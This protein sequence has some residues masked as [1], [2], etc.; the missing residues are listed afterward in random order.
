MTAGEW[1]GN[2]DNEANEEDPAKCWAIEERNERREETLRLKRIKLAKHSWDN[3]GEN[4]RSVT[5]NDKEEEDDIWKGNG[6]TFAGAYDTQERI[7]M[8]H[9]T[10]TK[11]YCHHDSQAAKDGD[12]NDIYGKRKE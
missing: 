12:S 9:C 3:K 8:Q 4:T 5:K 1:S 7:N 2:F 10:P 11:K 6:Y